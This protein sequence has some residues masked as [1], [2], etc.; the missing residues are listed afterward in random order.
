[1]ELFTDRKALADAIAGL[2]RV[3]VDDK[4]Q[5]LLLSAFWHR[6]ATGDNTFISATLNAMPK[7]SRVKAARQ[8]AEDMFSVKVS[9]DA[10]TKLLKCKNVDN[11]KDEVDNDA[12]ELA[13]TIHWTEYKRER[14]ESEYDGTKLV[15]K[16]RKQINTAIALATENGDDD[17]V[18]IL[19]AMLG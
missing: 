3:K 8:Y 19:T 9:I 18:A 4:I 2:S 12:L 15:D 17:T 14:A 11:F 10:K 6:M 1:M 13:A 16:V 7:G 5:T